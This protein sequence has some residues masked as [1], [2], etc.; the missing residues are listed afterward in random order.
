MTTRLKAYLERLDGMSLRERV[1]IFLMLAGVLVALSMTFVLDPLV[2][3][4]KQ[5]SQK[6]AQSQAQTEA[7]ETQMQVLTEASKIDPD[8]SNKMRLALLEEQRKNAIEVLSGA[9]QGLVGADR[10]VQLLQELL[11]QNSKLKLV[12]IK[13]LP[14]TSLLEEKPNTTET[15]T[16]NADKKASPLSALCLYRHGVEISVE[17]SYPELLAYMAALERMPWRVHWSSASLATQD[18]PTTR[19][20]LTLFT[21]SLDKTWLSV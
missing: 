7:L 19:L 8:A 9:R 20:T 2:S 11:G 6:L 1:M 18:Y 21:L 12:G 15:K 10:M 17:G 4:Q 14:V 5:L 13:T 16:A 3:Q